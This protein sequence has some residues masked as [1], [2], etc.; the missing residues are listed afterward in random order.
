MIRSGNILA[1]MAPHAGYVY[2]GDIAAQTFKNISDI[3]F[4]TIVIIGHYSFQDAV[5]YTCPVDYFEPPL[6]QGPGR[7]RDG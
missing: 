3:D 4:D 1:A 7:Y 6:R 2:S 5:A